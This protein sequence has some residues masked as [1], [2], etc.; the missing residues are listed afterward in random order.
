MTQRIPVEEALRLVLESTPVLPSE[1]IPFK[2]AVARVLQEEVRAPHDYPPFEKAM[3]D[4]YA[5][6]S[7]DVRKVPRRLRVVQEIQAGMAPGS[8]VRVESGT[9]ARIMTGAPMPPG[10]DAVLMV[11][12]SGIP[13]DQPDMVEVRAA[14]T[15][16]E[17]VAHRGEDVRSG[18]I[19]LAAGELIG[20]AEIGVLASCGTTRVRVGGRPRVSLL[21]TGDELV[22]A[23]DDPGPGQIRN[24]NGPVLEAL[25]VATGC[26]TT[27]LG[28]GPDD[29]SGLRRAIERGLGEDAL[30]L[31]GGVSMGVYDLVSKVLRDLGTEILFEKVAIKPGRP[32]TFGRCGSTLIFGCPG[33][34]V[35][36]YVIFLLFARPSLRKMM[37]F[38]QPVPSPLRGVLT[39]PVK[40]RPGRTVY[41]QAR[42]RWT[43]SGY[44]VEVIPT[45]GSADFVSCARGNALVIAPADSDGMSGGDEVE[46][47]LI[48]DFLKR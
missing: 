43:A 45:S 34:P 12:E 35:S 5:V 44:N 13:P 9:A 11:E 32:F 30:L 6:R 23:G 26:V 27:N 36:S 41:H 10:S 16:G 39:K 37:G 21:A 47:L 18:E 24:S 20:P 38:P 15:P 28:I 4:G 2:D 17:N 46:F 19:L 3:M 42:A 40:Q 8:L 25:S 31:T 1:E 33:N 48:E 7:E 22:E 29:E 14:L